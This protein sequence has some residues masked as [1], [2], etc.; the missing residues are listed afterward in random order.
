MTYNISWWIDKH[1]N[2]LKHFFVYLG[3]R[4]LNIFIFH[5]VAY[6]V[7]SLMK[8]WYYGLDI[9]Q[10]GCHMVIHDYSQQDYFWILYT[11]VGVGIP[12]AGSWLSEII[13]GKIREY[14]ASS[15]TQSR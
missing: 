14:R 2:T 9:R 15:G 11:I 4:T 7:A 12:L 5:I 13:A 10:I 8:I 1:E 3:D 6:K